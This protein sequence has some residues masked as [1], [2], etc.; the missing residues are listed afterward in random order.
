MEGPVSHPPP[1]PPNTSAVFCVRTG[2][3]AGTSV[4]TTTGV[5]VSLAWRSRRSKTSQLGCR[6]KHWAP[7][8]GFGVGWRQ[9]EI[10]KLEVA[11][12]RFRPLPYIQDRLY[13]EATF[14]SAQTRLHPS[15]CELAVPTTVPI[16]RTLQL[17]TSAPRVQYGTLH[18]LQDPGMLRALLLLLLLLPFFI[19]YTDEKTLPSTGD[20]TVNRSTYISRHVHICT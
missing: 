14:T 20:T 12:T 7:S 8:K 17:S 16:Q 4:T 10:P 1:Q 13:V 19:D 18:A 11:I 5:S 9:E 2:T 3:M 15:E 6:S